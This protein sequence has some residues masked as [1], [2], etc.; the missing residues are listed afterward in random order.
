MMYVAKVVDLVTV[1]GILS[2]EGKLV[3]SPVKNRVTIT[4]TG[5]GD[6]EMLCNSM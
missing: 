1:H 6:S 5:K 2:P 3:G 4:S